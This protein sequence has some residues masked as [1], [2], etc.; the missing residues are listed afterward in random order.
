VARQRKVEIQEYAVGAQS[1]DTS[2][3][4]PRP[5]PPRPAV[6][7]GDGAHSVAPSAHAARTVASGDAD[8]VADGTRAAGGVAAAEWLAATLGRGD[9]TQVVKVHV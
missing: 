5:A 2:S 7:V 8:I 1:C 3:S 4:T 6:I 9:I